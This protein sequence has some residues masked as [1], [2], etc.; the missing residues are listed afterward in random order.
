MR[1]SEPTPETKSEPPRRLPYAAVPLNPN[2]A[3]DP[4]GE[5]LYTVASIRRIREKL[6]DAMRY[7]RLTGW[8]GDPELC[9]SLDELLEAS[10][11]SSHRDRI[12]HNMRPLET[13]ADVEDPDMR[14]AQEGLATPRQLINL[15]IRYPALGSLELAKLS[16]PLDAAA[17]YEMDVDVCE[18]VLAAGG[19]IVLEGPRYK[20]KT[21]R[22][23]I[24]AMTF[25][26]K[27]Q[28]AKL[29]TEHGTIHVVTRKS[30]L[31]RGD[32]EARKY[33]PG[34]G[35]EII[36]GVRLAP[37]GRKIEGCLQEARIYGDA[38]I[39]ADLQWLQPIATSYYAKYVKGAK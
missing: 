14:D 37:I 36:R 8:V 9:K 2:K 19:D 29:A 6:D 24:P 21:A 23:D 27:Q 26:R 28:I 34:L 25:L 33:D 16:H 1:L 38:S 17:T 39:Q 4:Y 18:A 15:L 35:L 20:P 30:Y 11:F 13:L 7:A 3:A 31:V 32:K 5:G 12:D 22:P 10:L